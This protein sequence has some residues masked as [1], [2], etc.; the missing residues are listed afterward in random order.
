MMQVKLTWYYFILVAGLVAQFFMK[1]TLDVQNFSGYCH[2]AYWDCS[3]FEYYKQILVIM[4]FLMYKIFHFTTL[5][6]YSLFFMVFF[7][8]F[9]IHNH[10]YSLLKIQHELIIYLYLTQFEVVDG[11]LPI[12]LLI[13]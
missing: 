6:E 4:Q 9:F 5:K 10:E 12:L 3:S 1:L 8:F 13:E 7:L 11:I 2:K